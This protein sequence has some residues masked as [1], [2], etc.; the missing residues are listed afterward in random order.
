MKDFISSLGRYGFIC[1]SCNTA[2]LFVDILPHSND[3][4]IKDKNLSNVINKISKRK[5]ASQ[6]NIPETR[7][8]GKV[9][10]LNTQ[11]GLAKKAH[12]PKIALSMCINCSKFGKDTCPGPSIATGSYDRQTYYCSSFSRKHKRE[13]F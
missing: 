7:I 13:E 4:D 6:L 8:A 12:R 1:D 11:N 3:V 9:N 5:Y 2:F 10:P